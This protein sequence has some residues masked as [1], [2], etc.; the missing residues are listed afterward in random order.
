MSIDGGRLNAHKARTKD[1]RRR[2]D[3]KMKGG[4]VL[5]SA[6]SEKVEFDSID[7]VQ[8]EKI[9]VAIR[10]KARKSRIINV[11]LILISS[12]IAIVFFYLFT[13]KYSY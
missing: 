6:S 12:V 11:I 2:K 9:K 3:G 5:R 10:K 8:L 4:K 1:F 7:P 13:E